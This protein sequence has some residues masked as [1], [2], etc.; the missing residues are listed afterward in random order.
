MKESILTNNILRKLIIILSSISLFIIII[1][2]P[3]RY[4]LYNNNF[5]KSLCRENGVY[6]VLEKEDIEKITSGV[7]QFFKH[8]IPLKEFNLKSDYRFF[9]QNEISHLNDVKILLRKIMITFYA[10]LS[11]FA[12][13]LILL[14]RRNRLFYIKDVSIIF[15]C[16]SGLMIFILVILFFLGRNFSSLF[17][18]FHYIFFPQGNWAFS[19]DALIITIFPFGFFYDFF[20][21]LVISSFVISVILF[22]IF[23]ILLISVNVLINNKKKDLR[24]YER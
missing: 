10:A 8:D 22:I 21:K 4:Y 9:N 18:N 14:I 16:S 23:L 6:D 13:S 5:Y 15:L 19:S 24:V 2:A 7:I 12:V 11:F 3:L 17:E 20:F 1:F